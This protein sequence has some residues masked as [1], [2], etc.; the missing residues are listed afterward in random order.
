MEEK[1][2]GRPRVDTEAVNLRLSREMLQAIDERRRLESDLPTRPEMI[3]RAL[4]QWLAAS[5]E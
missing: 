2:K 1:K 4:A 5:E 3:R